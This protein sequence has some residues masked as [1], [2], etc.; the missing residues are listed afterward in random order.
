MTI[1]SEK[2][3]AIIYRIGG[4]GGNPISE[5]FENCFY[6]SLAY[7]AAGMSSNIL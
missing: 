2:I 4:G 1:K 7:K 6:S 5:H 3:F